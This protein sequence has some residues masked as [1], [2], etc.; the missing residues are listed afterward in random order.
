MKWVIKSSEGVWNGESFASNPEYPKKFLYRGTALDI[1][2]LLE[3]R[4]DV[5][6]E[7]LPCV[8]T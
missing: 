4:F 6:C 1:A 3:S 7:V 5:I 8:H 2:V